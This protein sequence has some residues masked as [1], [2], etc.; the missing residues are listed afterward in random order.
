MTDLERV[1]RAWREEERRWFVRGTAGGWNITRDGDLFEFVA[2]DLT[3]HGATRCTELRDAACAR[4]ALTALRTPGPAV[5][6]AIGRH[7][8]GNLSDADC[9]ALMG[10][11]VDAILGEP[12]P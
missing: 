2:D 11:I 9:V 4:A 1:A 12:Q 5:I 10:V 6:A 8:R 3:N 7:V